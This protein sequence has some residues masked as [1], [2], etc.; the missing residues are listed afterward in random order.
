MTE[1]PTFGVLLAR[2]SFQRQLSPAALSGLAKVSESELQNVFAGAKPSS[3]LLLR[4]APALNWHDVDLFVLAGMSMPD[5]LA[6]LDDEAGSWVASLVNQAV[7]LRPE[8][9][10]RVR[11]FAWSLPQRS[12]TRPFLPK[13][14][15]QYEQHEPGFGVVLVRM[16]ANRN[17]NWQAAAKTLLCLTGLGL[18]GATIGQIARGSK[19]LTPDLLARLATVLGIPSGDLAAVTGIDL[20]EEPPPAHPAAAELA[21]LIW[22]VRR[23]TTGQ[24]RQVLDEAMS[25]RQ[26]DR[27]RQTPAT[28][29]VQ[30]C[31]QRLDWGSPMDRSGFGGD[32]SL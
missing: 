26:S 6:P 18:S 2:L 13:P 19:E 31:G 32:C 5:E 29:T 3:S 27:F 24:V 22:D 28:L 14:Y 17:L 25:L 15:E 11:R 4:L 21:G 16:L 12:R 7:G 30:C 8:L 23:L 20:P 1:Y 10:D 9:I